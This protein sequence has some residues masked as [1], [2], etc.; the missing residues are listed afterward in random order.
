M[1][2]CGLL[3]LFFLCPNG[4]LWEEEIGRKMGAGVVEME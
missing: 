4:V 1:S 3:I 2:T